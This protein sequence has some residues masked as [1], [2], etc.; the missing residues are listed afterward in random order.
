[1]LKFNSIKTIF[2]IVFTLFIFAGCVAPLLVAA[3]AGAGATYSLTTDAITDETQ[4]SK[5]TIV[6]EFVNIIRSEKGLLLYVSIS[7][8]KVRGEI[9]K[10]K[11]YLDVIKVNENTSNIK[12]RVRKGFQLL[13]DKEEAMNLYKQLIVKIK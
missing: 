4:V 1:M 11:V 6:E 7:E 12:V 8:G 5:E 2:L 3:G 13:P 9:G 10:K